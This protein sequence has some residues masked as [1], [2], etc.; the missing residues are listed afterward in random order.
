MLSKGKIDVAVSRMHYYPGDTVSGS[1]RLALKKPVKARGVSVSLI[2][3]EWATRRR[4][5]I[6]A[7]GPTIDINVRRVYDFRLDLDDE[8]K[9][10]GPGQTYPFE[11]RV[12]DDLL[13][14][15]SRTSELAGRLGQMGQTAAEL[16]GV[17]P[18]QRIWWYLLAKLDIPRRRDVKKKVGISIG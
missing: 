12:P 18:Q 5:G 4:I 2:G 11:I 17:M 6:A 14:E 9:E 8:E 3:D 13:G 16:T 1:I 7:G 15:G 10:Y